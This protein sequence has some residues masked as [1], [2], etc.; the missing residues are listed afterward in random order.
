MNQVALLGGMAPVGG[1][2]DPQQLVDR[3]A[4]ETRPVLFDEQVMEP[5]QFPG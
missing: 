2:G 1:W 5:P 3:L 4:P